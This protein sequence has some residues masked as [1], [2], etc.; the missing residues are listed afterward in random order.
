MTF[1]AIMGNSGYPAYE[2][3]VKIFFRYAQISKI[4]SVVR[5][6]APPYTEMISH[7]SR[8][9][10]VRNCVGRIRRQLKSTFHHKHISS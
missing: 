6:F 5:A 10:Y 1:C 2:R 7:E 3:K 4:C 8:Y 9:I